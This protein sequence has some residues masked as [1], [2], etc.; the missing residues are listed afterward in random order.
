[1]TTTQGARVDLTEEEIRHRAIEWRREADK[2]ERNGGAF[3]IGW[4]SAL[5]CLAGE[6][7]DWADR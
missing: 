7:D 6:L 5:R 3:N 1:M 2:L 4:A